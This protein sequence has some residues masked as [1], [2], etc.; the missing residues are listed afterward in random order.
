MLGRF[1][2]G[3]GQGNPWFFGGVQN[4]MFLCFVYPHMRLD[5]PFVNCVDQVHIVDYSMK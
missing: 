4:H 1:G 5:L 3:S 2:I